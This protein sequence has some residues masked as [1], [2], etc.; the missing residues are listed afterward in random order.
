MWYICAFLLGCTLGAA[1]VGV[2][3]LLNLQRCV[4]RYVKPIGTLRIDRS[5]PD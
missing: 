4:D 5:D 1:V 2:I 3:L